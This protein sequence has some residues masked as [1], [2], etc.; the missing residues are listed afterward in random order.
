MMAERQIYKLIGIVGPCGSGKTTLVN[1]LRFLGMHVRHIAQEHSYVAAM[2][3]KISNPDILI[4]LDASYPETIRRRKL[5]WTMDEYQEQQR[6]L[7]DARQHADLYI[8]TDSQNPDEVFYTVVTFLK[9][10]A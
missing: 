3:Q 7:A 6:R 4:F 1:R 9:E 5:N 10:H 2:W 8:F